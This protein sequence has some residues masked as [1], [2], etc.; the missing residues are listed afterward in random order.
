[1]YLFP[2]LFIYLF[3]Y[4]YFSVCDM[5]MREAGGRSTG[6]LLK[7]FSPIHITMSNYFVATESSYLCDPSSKYHRQAWNQRCCQILG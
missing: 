1:M 2:D 3:I 6:E 7:L 4:F 5:E